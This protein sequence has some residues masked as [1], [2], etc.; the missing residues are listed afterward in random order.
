[1]QE[2]TLYTSYRSSMDE[3]DYA[4]ECIFSSHPISNYRSICIERTRLHPKIY[5]KYSRNIVSRLVRLNPKRTFR[6]ARE[7][8][9]RNTDTRCGA[10][11]TGG[12]GRR[13]RTETA[14]PPA[15]PGNPNTGCRRGQQAAQEDR[16]SSPARP[17]PVGGRTAAEA[18]ERSRRTPA[19]AGTAAVGRRRPAEAACR[20]RRVCRRT[21]LDAL[22]RR[23]GTACA[24]AA[25][26][27]ASGAL[28]CLGGR[29]GAASRG[30]AAPGPE[31]EP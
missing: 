13:G 14:A 6:K 12:T 28:R 21:A 30:A 22:A 26:R 5:C 25:P 31:P 9:R 18:S 2:S 10:C 17:L 23:G 24:A 3:H 19:V 1:M 11:S 29:G 16:C 7:P 8:C 27:T 20:S 15:G 4:T